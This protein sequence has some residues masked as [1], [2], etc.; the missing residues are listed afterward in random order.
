MR[1]FES[2]VIVADPTTLELGVAVR[3]AL[4]AFRLRV[5]LYQCVQK[6]NLLDLLSG[7]IADAQYVVL[8][9]GGFHPPEP[10][11]LHFVRMVDQVDGSWQEME[12]WLTPEMVRE[13]VSLPGRTIVVTGGCNAG[14][15]GLAEA[16]LSTGC[17]A[18]VAPAE[19]IDADAVVLFTIGLFYHLLQE[20]REPA[21]ACSL[22]EAVKRAAAMDTTI[23]EGTH[24]YRCF[25]R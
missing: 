4:E 16:F 10:E 24:L 8:C 18:Y 15:E 3:A 1:M 5:H 7:Q 6:R 9:A 19:P 20:E 23:R 12:L 2:V 22:E 17:R 25:S 13:K 14:T 21:A 11:G